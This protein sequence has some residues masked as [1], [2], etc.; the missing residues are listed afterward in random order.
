MLVICS[1]LAKVQSQSSYRAAVSLHRRLQFSNG[2]NVEQKP[3]SRKLEHLFQRS[4]TN[5]LALNRV[6][7]GLALIT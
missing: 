2:I 5:A 1:P 6:T 4:V 7:K 3:D